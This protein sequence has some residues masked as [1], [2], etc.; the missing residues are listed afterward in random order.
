MT[1]RKKL[2]LEGVPEGQEWIEFD[3]RGLK[4]TIRDL[5][6]INGHHVN[7]I[8]GFMSRVAKAVTELEWMIKA[9]EKLRAHASPREKKTEAAK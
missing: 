7:R 4:Y 5:S 6:F 8:P 9:L 2:G 1:A 3:I